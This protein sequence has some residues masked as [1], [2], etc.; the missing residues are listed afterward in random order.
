MAATGEP[1]GR[2]RGLYERREH[3]QFTRIEL[4]ARLEN[5]RQLVVQYEKGLAFFRT[6]VEDTRYELGKLDERLGETS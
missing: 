1:L 3:D 5:D 2:A 4:A 6:R